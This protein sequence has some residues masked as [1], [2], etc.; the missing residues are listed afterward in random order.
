[1]LGGINNALFL[2]SFAG[3]F[4]L[5][6]S[7][8]LLLRWAFSEVKSVSRKTTYEM[9]MSDGTDYLRWLQLLQITSKVKL[10]KRTL[11]EHGIKATLTQD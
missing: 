7:H 11:H 5:G 6:Y 8:H 4:V 2:T 1:M 3:F 9:V 10:L